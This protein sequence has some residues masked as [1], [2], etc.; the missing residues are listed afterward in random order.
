MA[1][2]RIPGPL[3]A[4]RGNRVLRDGTSQRTPGMLPGPIGGA[5]PGH[6]SA[7][8]PLRYVARVEAV[9]DAVSIG[10]QRAPEAIWR[11]T[12]HAI[13][14]LVKGLI[15]GLLMAMAVEGVCAVVGGAAGGLV[16]AALGALAGGVGAAPGAVA[17]A[18]AGAELGLS[19]GAALLTWLGLGFLLVS[20]GEGL[21]ALTTRVYDATLKAWNACDGSNPVAEVNLAGEALATAVGKL[22]Q[23]ILTAI[24]ARLAMRVQTSANAAASGAKKN[25]LA[26]LADSKLGKGFAKWVVENE[27]ALLRN[28]KLQGRPKPK[29]S[30]KPVEPAQ[31]PSQVKKQARKEAGEGDDKPP[32]KGRRQE[33]GPCDHLKQ[34]NGKGPYRGGA[35]GK[36]SKPVNDGKDSHHMPAKDA[37][38]L[39]IND[40]PAIQMDPTDHARTWSNGQMPGSI[41]YRE[42]I[43]GLISDGKWRDA[44]TTEIKD[45]RRVAREA[46]DARK[47]NEAMLEMMEYF[48]CLEKNNLL[49]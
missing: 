38:P 8:D 31:T 36:T 26:Q 9:R 32:G 46:G 24:V 30:E 28:P 7:W 17:G 33:P 10:I 43:A 35:H 13:G 6:T 40:G 45:V 4:S 15:P 19:L 49:K 27:Q 14:D 18:A 44:M 3:N 37:S 5:H 2:Y 34:G 16:G 47:Y 39:S 41:D 21:M 11:E 22:F 25:V 42:A 23:L 48:K 1:H 12:G 29:A 20:I